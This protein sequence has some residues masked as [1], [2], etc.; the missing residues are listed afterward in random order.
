M[1]KVKQ[2]QPKSE[3]FKKV[4]RIAILA[5]PYALFVCRMVLQTLDII[6]ASGANKV[7]TKLNLQ[8]SIKNPYV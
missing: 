7:I 4:A 8:P 1:K 2:K 6:A 5:I 3:I